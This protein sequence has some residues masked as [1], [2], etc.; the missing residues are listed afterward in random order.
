MPRPLSYQIGMLPSYQTTPAPPFYHM[1]VDFAGPFHIRTGHTHKLVII[2]TYACLFLCLTTRA[3]H[4]DLCTDLSTTEFMATLCRFTV[5]QGSSAHV[6]S[7]DGTNFAGTR[8]DIKKL[9]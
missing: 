1:G 5:R 6:Y 8:A 4:L 7:N 9:Q 2:K 3:I